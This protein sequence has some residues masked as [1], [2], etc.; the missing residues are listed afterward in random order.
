M[1]SPQPLETRPSR[2]W[3]FCDISKLCWKFT[4]QLDGNER[5][6]QWAT[7]SIFALPQFH[8]RPSADFVPTL[9]AYLFPP[10]SAVLYSPAPFLFFDN[11]FSQICYCRREMS[12][13]FQPF[14]YLPLTSHFT[15][16]PFLLLRR[17]LT[18]FL[19]L[20]QSQLPLYILTFP[21]A[22]YVTFLFLFPCL[23][24]AVKLVESA[25]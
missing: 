9:P 11:S 14:L 23:G 6:D 1:N 21:W 19:S 17:R 16:L 18:V 25:A 24:A 10:P 3:V 8:P 2:L 15:V 5:N 4:W 7:G 13:S 12:N 20:T 22:F